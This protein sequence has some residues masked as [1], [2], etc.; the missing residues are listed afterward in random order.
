MLEEGVSLR[1]LQQY[2]G[3]SQMETTVIYLHLTEV[4]ETKAQ[5]ALGSLFRQVIA[6][7]PPLPSAGRSGG[8]NVPRPPTGR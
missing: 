3:H 1:Q 4:S 8:G 6:P 7:S 2:L 5:E